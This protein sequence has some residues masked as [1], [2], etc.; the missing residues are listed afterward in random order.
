MT[1]NCTRKLLDAMPRAQS[2]LHVIEPQALGLSA[3]GHVG[4]FRP[5]ASH[6]LWPLLEQATGDTMTCSD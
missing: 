2:N 6:A 3:I 5:Q 4:A 1:E